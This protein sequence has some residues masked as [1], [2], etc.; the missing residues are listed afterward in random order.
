MIT[1]TS[2][3]IF[4]VFFFIF[5]VFFLI[6]FGRGYRP[7][8]KEKKIVATGIL[9]I[10]SSPKSAQVYL[11]NEL[12]GVTDISLT[13]Q[14]G[15]Y[16]VEVKKDGYLPWRKEIVL[17]GELVINLD[18]LLLPANPSLSPQTNIG[19]KKAIPVDQT[20]KIILFVDNDNQEKDG[21]YLFDIA[22]KGFSF[23]PPLRPLAK[24]TQFGPIF[25]TEPFYQAQIE[26]SPDY[27]QALIRWP[28]NAYII[29]LDEEN[30]QPFDI[31]TS[32]QPLLDAWREEKE[33]QRLKVLETFGKD[34]VKIASDSF[35]IIAFS[36]DETKI[37]YQ[38]TK[39]ITLPPFLK[40]PLLVTNQTREERNLIPG[41]VYVYDRKEDK[42]FSL[43]SISSALTNQPKSDIN[44]T[45]PILW[46]PDSKHLV[47]IKEKKIIVT[48]YDGTNER[49]VYSA[50]FEESFLNVGPDGRLIILAN[51]NPQ[52][53]PQSDIYS[54]SLK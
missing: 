44:I 46:Y 37:L 25:E 26:F 51:L 30:S 3:R 12:K 49:I 1:T 35:Q 15:K 4:L 33:I 5:A 8:L 7:D 34:F 50:L 38:P 10:T 28:N 40:T 19:V 9:S 11:N 42:N 22:K 23:F 47:Y 41:K 45:F 13:L 14:P 52:V 48:D 16:Q 2:K 43:I 54:I 32:Y 39:K 29:N 27:K 17:K 36:P 24:K 21:L 18:P 20:G 53:N 31:T 6:A